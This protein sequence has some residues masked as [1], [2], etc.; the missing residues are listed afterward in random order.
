[1]GTAATGAGTSVADE[2]TTPLR[3]GSR[4]RPASGGAPKNKGS[5]RSSLMDQAQY[6]VEREDAAR[7]AAAAARAT[8]ASSAAVPPPPDSTN[9]AFA[10]AAAAAAGEIAEAADFAVG[11][12]EGPPV[13][14][15]AQGE[16][17]DMTAYAE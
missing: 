4:K 11:S 1:M 15:R 9:A 6:A 10:A 12:P 14:T 16:A 2:A 5:K 17:T 7:A 8:P 3:R 13:D